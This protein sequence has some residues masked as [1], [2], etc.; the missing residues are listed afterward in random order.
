MCIPMIH[1]RHQK[2]KC[3]CYAD[4]K[5]FRKESEAMKVAVLGF[6]TVGFGVYEMLKNAGGLEQ[7]PVLVRPGKADQPYKVTSI[8]EIVNDPSVGAVAEVMG[9]VEPAFSYASAVLK[10]G[11]HFVT[12]NKALVA[13][14]G[15]ELDA[16][17]REKGVAFLFSAAC[18]GG[19][20]FLHNLALARESDSILSFGGILNGT[21]NYMLDAM[22][23]LHLDYADVLADAQRLGYAEADPTADVSGLD[24]LRKIMLAC[25]VAYG[26][27]P[28][29]GLLNEGVESVTAS[30]VAHFQSRGYTCRLIASGGRA[31][32][33]VYAY[34]EPVLVRDGAAE[35]AVLQ[36]FNMARYEGGC[37]GP[38]VLMGQGAGRWPT[39]SAV[40]RDL[41][42]ILRGERE[43]F[44]ANLRRGEVDNSACSHSYYVR[45]PAALAGELPAASAELDGEL[46]RMITEPIPVSQMHFTANRLRKCG[47]SVF[48]AA[49]R[50]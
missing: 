36:N 19:V 12:S 42:G 38:I 1:C 21:T 31:E 15:P 9:G 23:R 18:G 49:V 14:K 16:I 20:P 29:D 27:L 50:E 17:A 6:G 25:A 33:G 13:A 39:A 48:F 4:T 11:K 22:Q 28:T 32:D 7:G 35:C 45:L 41:S 46:C 8:E 10:A 2:N 5:I 40:L 43:M 44:P 34:V 3:F 47:A 37:A 26:T 30:D 24:A